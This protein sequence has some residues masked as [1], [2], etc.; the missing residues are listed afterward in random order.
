M[1]MDAASVYRS[2]TRSVGEIDLLDFEP[3]TD[4][5]RADVLE[6]LGRPLK[7][8]P[9]KLFYD[10]RGSQLFDEICELPEY[11]PTRTELGLMRE[12]GPAMAAAIGSRALLVEYGSGSSL[13]T[14][15][16]LDH[17]HDPAGYV[18]IDISGAHL[19]QSARSLQRSY[20]S[21]TIRPVC[22]DYTRPFS[23]PSFEE[24][25]PQR[26]V[27]YFPGSTIGN[28]DPQQALE[29]LVG[30]RETCGPSSGLLIGVD[31]KKDPA[32]LH[33]A[34][35][36]AAGVTAAF[37]LNVLRR[38]NREIGANFDISGFAHY[39]FYNPRAGRVEMHLISR[40][41]QRVDLGDG[42]S[43]RFAAGEAIHTENSH[44]FSVDDFR[45]L[46]ARA[47]YRAERL[48]L[49]RNA[50]FSVHYLVAEE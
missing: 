6:G 20:P 22:A 16:L 36:D 26:V 27:A 5:V 24:E 2:P 11:Y 31:L 33:A 18:P 4:D 28:F 37:N 34:Y 47:G 29:F 25:T 13:K 19:M 32:I 7:T 46:A 10:E 38:V 3:A 48:W 15:V 21:L 50:W 14:R 1:K 49:D 42:A 35:N 43:A 45:S 12:H 23:L 40:R 17:L 8:L 39:A 30:I 41:A 9:C 44:K